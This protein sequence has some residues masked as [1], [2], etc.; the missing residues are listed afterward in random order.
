[1]HARQRMGMRV[2]GLAALALFLG[3]TGRAV[4]QFSV[5][6][7][8]DENGHATLTNTSGFSSS[9]GFGVGQDTGPGGLSNALRY[10]LLNPPGLVAGDVRVL[11]A[12]GF[13][14]LIRFNIAT[15]PT[16]GLGEMVLYSLPGGGALADTGFPSANYANLITT[17]EIAGLISYTPTVGQPGFVAGAAGPVTYNITSPDL[18]A[19][20]E[21]SS[22]ALF[23]VTGLALVGWRRWRRK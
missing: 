1:M 13:S 10:D 5:T 4:A 19:V 17:S 14:D 9:L 18:A 11:D 22:L 20:P 23:T 3:G 12:S 16:G 8:A 15:S 6:I 2:I 21:P 7:T